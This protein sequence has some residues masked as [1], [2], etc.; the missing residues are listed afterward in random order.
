[1]NQHLTTIDIRSRRPRQTSH[2]DALLQ[3][4]AAAFTRLVHAA[5][6][7]APDGD[8]GAPAASHDIADP[9]TCRTIG[10]ALGLPPHVVRTMTRVFN[11]A[12]DWLSA[13]AGDGDDDGL[14]AVM[15][16]VFP[17]APLQL[18]AGGAR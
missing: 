10:G 16:A 2:A 7:T 9:Q 13:A 6:A 14:T 12:A 11:E 8:L 3:E 1:M 17:P 18:V 5:L 15:D 4:H